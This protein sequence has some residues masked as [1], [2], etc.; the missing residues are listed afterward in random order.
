MCGELLWPA[1][2][3][4]DDSTEP[5]QFFACLHTYMCRKPRTSVEEALDQG[6]CSCSV[7]VSFCEPAVNHKQ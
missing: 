1:M 2:S 6:Q 5:L 4:H 7:S 3:M